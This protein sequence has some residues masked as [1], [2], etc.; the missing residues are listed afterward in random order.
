M[1]QQRNYR[2]KQVKA[3][4]TSRTSHTPDVHVLFIVVAYVDLSSGKTFLEHLQIICS[5]R[6]E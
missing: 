6:S 4:K 3:A 1:M 5:Y 2:K